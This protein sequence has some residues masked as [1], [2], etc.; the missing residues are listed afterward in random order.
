MS[1]ARRRIG[2]APLEW[3]FNLPRG[4]EGATPARNGVWRKNHLITA[5][6]G[7]ILTVADEPDIRTRYT[8]QAGN[9]GGTGYPQ[10]RLLALL[11]CGTRT[12]IDAVFAPTTTGETT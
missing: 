9:H 1:Q 2:P 10:T 11:T 3:L 8:K 5:I 6:D 12:I 7:T 4:P